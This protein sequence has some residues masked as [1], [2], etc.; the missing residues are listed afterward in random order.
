MFRLEELGWCEFFAGQCGEWK[1]SGQFPARV[2]EEH[3]GAYRLFSESGEWLAELAG[4]LRHEAKSRAELPAVGDWVI[5]CAN[6][7]A[8]RATVQRVLKRRSAFSRKIAGR[9]TEEQIVAAN[10]DV[11]LVVCSLNQ[12]FNV[13]RIERYL[14]LTWESGARPVLV[15][16][17]R[18]LCEDAEALQEKAETAA[19]GA[20]VLPTS[21]V[22]AEGIEELRKMVRGETAALLG[23]SGV[24]KSSLIN[25][26]LGEQRQVTKE[27]RAGDHRGKHATTSRQLLLLPGGGVLIDTPGM[28]E[29]QL[30]DVGVGI[31][32]TFGEIDKLAARCKFRDCA[33]QGE[34]GCA[35]QAAI[36]E[37][38]LEAERLESF[39]KLRREE[40]FLEAKQ[41]AAARAERTKELRRLMKSVKRFYKDRER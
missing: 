12:E 28:R 5:A 6:A 38:A 7:G 23:S 30:W 3:R 15:L 34:P 11:A 14:A 21:A 13:R 2:A 33:H 9:K 17:K 4:K 24:G 20:P 32:R 37:G 1:E 36:E 10:V 41:D 22:R 16:N 27:V 31:A 8:A 29:L 19:M 40:R 26:M 25:A 35:V 18:D 39:H